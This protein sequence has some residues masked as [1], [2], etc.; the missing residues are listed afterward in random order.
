MTYGTMFSINT[1]DNNGV[2]PL[3]QTCIKIITV[4][5]KRGYGEIFRAFHKLIGTYRH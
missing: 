2:Y 4:A 1:S 3:W 5:Q